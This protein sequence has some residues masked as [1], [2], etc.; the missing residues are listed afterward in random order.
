MKRHLKRLLMMVI[1]VV[2]ILALAMIPLYLALPLAHQAGKT[3]G[4]LECIN[5]TEF[6]TKSE[7]DKLEGYFN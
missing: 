5:T 2:F 1:E 4:F 7:L 6:P 3:D